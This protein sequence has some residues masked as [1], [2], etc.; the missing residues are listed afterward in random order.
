[1]NTATAN[2]IQGGFRELLDSSAPRDAVIDYLARWPALLPMWIPRDNQIIRNLHLFD[3]ETADFAYHRDD[4][5]GELWRFIYVGD[6]NVSLLDGNHPGTELLN[7][8]AKLGRWRDWFRQRL[9]TYS[10]E[11]PFD[12][13]EFVSYDPELYLI[14]GRITEIE[15]FQDHPRFE[16]WSFI[17]D[18]DSDCI[19]PRTFDNLLLNVSDQHWY[20]DKPLKIGQYR[21]GELTVDGVTTVKL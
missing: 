5:P 1:L 8:L 9:E 4:T 13:D 12:R 19:W 10:H 7:L 15:Q 14:L 2:D 17:S 6:P 16:N 21:D 11:F 20:K 18:V 3:D